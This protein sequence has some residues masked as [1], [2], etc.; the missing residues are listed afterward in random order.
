MIRWVISH[1]SAILVCGLV[2]GLVAQW[3]M[4]NP[5]WKDQESKGEP[6]PYG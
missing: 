2:V 4:R 3:L 6:P 5:T 1:W